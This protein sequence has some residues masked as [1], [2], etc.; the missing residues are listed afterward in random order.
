MT[1]S[2]DLTVTETHELYLHLLN[3][4]QPNGEAATDPKLLHREITQAAETRSPQLGAEQL[5]AFYAGQPGLD[6]KHLP[7]LRTVLDRAHRSAVDP[8][9][10]WKPRWLKTPQQRHY[11]HPRI[12]DH[13]LHHAV[14]G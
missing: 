4:K 10:T 2:L 1:D 5:E 6:E 11:A 8:K 12:T 3:L 9:F 14:N 7:A 13:A